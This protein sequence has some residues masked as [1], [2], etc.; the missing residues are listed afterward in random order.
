MWI[1]PSVCCLIAGHQDLPHPPQQDLYL[2]VL[3][4]Y[5]D[6]KP[7]SISHHAFGSCIFQCC[8]LLHNCT[9][10]FSEALLGQAVDQLISEN[11][12]YPLV[13]TPRLLLEDCS[14]CSSTEFFQNCTLFNTRKSWGC[15]TTQ[16]STKEK[17]VFASKKPQIRRAFFFGSGAKKMLWLNILVGCSARTSKSVPS[18]IN[19]VSSKAADSTAFWTIM[20]SASEEAWSTSHP[21]AWSFCPSRSMNC[22]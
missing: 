7:W 2:N 9:L 15:I 1:E 8:N 17:D 14:W 21:A 6:H 3:I 16:Q 10:W 5:T 4:L 13:S 18:P 20:R 11:I 22:C 12:H 19:T